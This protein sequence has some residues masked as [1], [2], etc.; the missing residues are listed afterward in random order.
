MILAMLKIGLR[1]P[2][3][4]RIVQQLGYH[5]LAINQ[6]AAYIKKQRI[7]FA[8]FLD[9]YKSRRDIILKTTPALT[10]YPCK[11][12]SSDDE[13]A[14]NVFTT[15]QLSFEQ[16]QEEASDDGREVKLLTLFPF[17][18]NQDISELLFQYV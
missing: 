13:S 11:L 3:C 9:D 12:S 10:E 14:L 6:A 8:S 4:R 15:W 16:L 18:D 17:S 2:S 5:A 1:Y 7:D